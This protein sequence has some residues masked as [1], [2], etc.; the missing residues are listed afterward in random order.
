MAFP[1]LCI[2]SF[3][4]GS[5]SFGKIMGLRKG[6][7]I[8]KRGS[9]NI[10]FANSLRVLGWKSAIWVLTGDIVKGFLPAY[11]AL[12]HF[13]LLQTCIIGFAAVMGHNHSIFLRFKGGKGVATMVGVSLALN[14]IITL[15]GGIVWIVVFLKGRTA[16][17]SSLI[18]IPLL[19]ILAL[20][21]DVQLFYFYLVF[22]VT[23]LA[24]H[25]FNIRN[26]V[27]GTEPKI[28]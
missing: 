14:P 10:G 2:I 20:L 9:G 19:S 23:I 18:M 24:T 1:A 6:I 3:L 26:L 4:V 17:V 5:I 13:S 15:V 11:Y 25:R 7:D 16:S 27:K 22:V 12:S 28:I 8:Q 21:F